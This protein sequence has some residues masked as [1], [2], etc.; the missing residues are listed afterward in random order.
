M[1]SS[2]NTHIH[3]IVL[4][5]MAYESFSLVYSLC[6]SSCHLLITMSKV[7]LSVVAQPLLLLST[8]CW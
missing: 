3:G 6:M 5:L 2:S 4:R 8:M 7:L 1:S